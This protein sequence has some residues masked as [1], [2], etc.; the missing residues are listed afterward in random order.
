MRRIRV[1]HI[2]HGMETFGGVESFLLQYYRNI[3]RSK[4]TFDF[5]MGCNNT[6]E[7]YETES[8]FVD[9]KFTTLYALE[10]GGNKISNYVQLVKGV[11][12]YLG[13]N[14]YDIVHVNTSNILLQTFLAL[15]MKTNG[16]K[17]AHSHSATPIQAKKTVKGY[18][19]GLEK[20]F[21]TPICQYLIRKNYDYM[22]AC[23]KNAGTALFGQRG[24]E[25]SRFTVIK[26]AIDTN[27][28]RFDESV[29]AYYRTKENINSNCIVYGTVGRLAESKN[30][31]FLIDVFAELHRRN[32]N[33]RLWL[34]GE[35]S[36]RRTIENKVVEHG[37]EDVVTLFGEKNNVAE[38]LMAMDCFI[39]PTVYEGLG[40]VAIE[41]QTTGLP[42]VASDAVPDE[43]KIT[44]R[45]VSIPL[46]F[47]VCK[48]AESIEKEN[49]NPNRKLSYESVKEAGYD[50][51][52]A[53]EELLSFYR[54]ISRGV[55]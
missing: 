7:K 33:S 49:I 8:I 17:I 50:I 53:A 9:S 14:H 51:E 25:D 46:N 6:F 16:I 34:I 10:T 29:R 32:S 31:L 2:L 37:L 3:D 43:A 44:D 24:V 5:V 13:E 39:F 38:Y 20:E 23:S 30:L 52:S 54:M 41:A 35:G 36:M 28:Y 21:I 55:E 48:W 45:F 18:I 4:V 1:L 11:N 40:I 42:V 47:P 12:T 27:V 19:K 22:L 15:F 26:N